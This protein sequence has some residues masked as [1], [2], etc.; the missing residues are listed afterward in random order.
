MHFFQITI[1]KYTRYQVSRGK[2]FS[3]IAEWICFNFLLREKPWSRPSSAKLLSWRNWSPR[4]PTRRCP[5]ITV[6]WAGRKARGGFTLEFSQTAS[7]CKWLNV[8]LLCLCLLVSKVQ[9]LSNSVSCFSEWETE[10]SRVLLLSP[11]CT[12]KQCTTIRS[13]KTNQGNIPCRREQSL[14][15]SGR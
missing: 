14:T 6:K 5:G 3:F 13:S 7:F 2:D 8:M 4:R 12:G 15:Q 9:F 1:L 11:W 10:T